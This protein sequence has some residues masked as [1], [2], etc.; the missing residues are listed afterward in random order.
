[1]I[2]TEAKVTVVA[3]EWYRTKYVSE[4]TNGLIN[5]KYKST[6]STR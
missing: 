2:T 6:V 4:S 1:M 3:I 5:D